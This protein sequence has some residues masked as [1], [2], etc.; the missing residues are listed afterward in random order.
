ME[1][2]DVS[3]RIDRDWKL[4]IRGERE[5]LRYYFS[6]SFRFLGKRIR[7]VV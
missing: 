5:E 4:D 6:F 7:S 2:R 3:R 1:W